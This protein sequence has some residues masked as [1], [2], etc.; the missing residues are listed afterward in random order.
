MYYKQY[1]VTHLTCDSQRVT[2][3]CFP[4]T[5]F[6]KHFCNWARFDATVQQLVEFFGASCYLDD[7]GSF[8]M[9]LGCCCESHRNKLNG[10]GL[11]QNML[12]LIIFENITNY[13]TG[14]K[15]IASSTKKS[16][17]SVATGT[18]VTSD[19][20]QYP[21]ILSVPRDCSFKSALQ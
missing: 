16:T 9:K 19:R 4:S 1:A 17:H 12:T 5:E 10:F 11:D 13:K 14:Y 7:F 20:I 18:T 8:L 15:S 3:L 21:T 6:P 2:K